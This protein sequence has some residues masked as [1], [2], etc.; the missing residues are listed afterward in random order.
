M[1]FRC[2]PQESAHEFTHES[3]ISQPMRPA[4]P[5]AKVQK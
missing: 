5:P 1:L 2:M 3:A 4:F